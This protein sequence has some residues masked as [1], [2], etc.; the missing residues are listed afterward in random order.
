VEG[1]HDLDKLPD[2][3]LDERSTEEQES[4]FDRLLAADSFFLVIAQSMN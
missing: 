4:E 2:S 1:T 3:A